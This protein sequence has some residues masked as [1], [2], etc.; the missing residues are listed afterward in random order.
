M[1][2]V[3]GIARYLYRNVLPRRHETALRAVPVLRLLCARRVGHAPVVWRSR[4]AG[5]E[6][7]VDAPLFAAVRREGRRGADDGDGLRA[8]DAHIPDVAVDPRRRQ[9]R[10]LGYFVLFLLCRLFSIDTLLRVPDEGAAPTAARERRFKACGVAAALVCVL[11]SISG[12]REHH[13]TRVLRRDPC[14]KQMSPT[15]QPWP[16]RH[17]RDACSMA[18]RCRFLTARRSQRGHVIAEK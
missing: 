15:A 12:R 13:P 9:G 8:R 2:V 10:E 14:G 6:R 1:L 11:C 3:F 18:W 17:R 16:P 5:G 7:I 4:I